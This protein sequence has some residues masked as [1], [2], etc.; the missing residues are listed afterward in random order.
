ME[1]TMR[2]SSHANLSVKTRSFTLVEMLVAIGAAAV[3]IAG[4]GQLFSSISGVVAVG[5]AVAEVNQL[6]RAIQERMRRDFEAFSRLPEDE[7]FLAIR[8]REIGGP[9][10]PIYFDSEDREADL[11]DIQAGLFN[12]PYELDPN[13]GQ[14]KGRAVYRRLDELIF[15]AFDNDGGGF[16]TAQAAGPAGEQAPTAPT[17][18]IYYGHAL[19]PAP[20]PDFPPPLDQFQLQ[21][22]NLLAPAPARTW[23]ADGDFGQRA[24]EENL[25]VKSFAGALKNGDPFLRVSAEARNEY[26]S[27]WSLARQPLLLLGGRAAGEQLRPFAGKEAI[28]D[29]D[30]EYAPFIR[31]I[32]T[33]NRV[34]Q[35]LPTVDGFIDEPGPNEFVVGPFGP[36]REKP[37]PRL[38]RHGR[39]DICAQSGDPFVGV[40]RWLEGDPPQDPPHTPEALAF[41]AG[42]FAAPVDPY[43]ELDTGQMRFPLWTL[44]KAMGSLGLTP[45][46]AAQLNRMGL[47]SAIAGVFARP[48]QTASAP[49]IDRAADLTAPGAQQA[50]DA[51][52]DTHALLAARC[53]SFEIA[54]TDGS[55]AN[56][57]I[58]FDNDGLPDVREGDLVWFDITR[59]NPRDPSPN[60]NNRAAPRFTWAEMRTR[61]GASGSTQPN[62]IAF[63]NEYDERALFVSGAE[64]RN[65]NFVSLSGGQFQ[66]R[67][68]PG[69]APSRNA[70]DAVSAQFL[71]TVFGPATR[72]FSRAFLPVYNPDITGG[73][74]SAAETD[75]ANE[76]IFIWPFRTP[77]ERGDYLDSAG[78]PNAWSKDI[79]LRVRLTLHDSQG[80]LRQ[81]RQFE[82]IFDLQ[83]RKL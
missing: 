3:V 74:P 9:D 35:S 81:G 42:R 10:N 64:A 23:L 41:D 2:S 71:P 11:R 40:R 38:I 18:R 82:F 20:D 66:P 50:E 19:K 58:D 27:S 26:A 70:A 43:G 48:L 77:S 32:E 12:D 65:P 69:L 67:P 68:G 61:Y 4:V 54:W 47:R 14:L 7:T 73:V 28:I 13:T 80:T 30:R 75:D 79:L 34:W 17:A 16:H 59:L 33:L 78:A 37:E 52:M 72:D 25:I 63:R 45:L 31:D 83:P 60:R 53:S 57:P 21:V 24:G 29:N 15:L 46:Q 55:T 8:M 56:Q 39:V 62:A 76:W 1:T 5:R 51:L 22:D 36:E 6:A 49:F 44:Q